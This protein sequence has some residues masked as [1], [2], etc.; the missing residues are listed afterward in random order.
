MFLGRINLQHLRR[1][2]KQ[3]FLPAHLGQSKP[4]NADD[5]NIDNGM[6]NSNS[7]DSPDRD[8]DPFSEGVDPGHAILS[9]L[10]SPTR[11]ISHRSL[12]DHLS[13][14]SRFLGSKG[15][16]TVWVIPVPLL[17]PST[18]EQAEKWSQNY[19][20]TIYK[21]NNPYGPHPSIVS[22]AERDLKR[23][24]KHF[25]SIA[26]SAGKQTGAR[27]LG[28]AVG[29]I[30]VDGMAA[31]SNSFAI[32]AGDARWCHS[33]T[34]LVGCRG[35]GNIMG[36]AVMRAIG[37]VARKRL[38]SAPGSEY[39]APQNDGVTKPPFPQDIEALAD[40]FLERPIT[41]IEDDYYR[42]ASI[43]R[44][45]YLCVG[46]NIYTTHEPC[47]MCSMAILHSRFQGVVFGQRMMRTGG[48]TA[49]GASQALRSNLSD[50]PSKHESRELFHT[51]TSGLGYGMFWRDELNWKLLAWQWDDQEQSSIPKIDSNTH[52]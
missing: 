6:D 46:L 3:E 44:D 12:M 9:M 32:V 50:D 42:Q 37:M 22:R 4:F 35:N 20:P 13:A 2:V 40:K 1:F 23:N 19:W 33:T 36:H 28:D 52:A 7:H 10:V 24:A 5:P 30:I 51:E 41:P 26:V 29:A 14:S 27:G 45:G 17:P 21:C 34:S 16:P 39:M 18:A 15:P 8:R 47:I 25:M 31:D 48:L 11:S 43:S 49:E 38:H